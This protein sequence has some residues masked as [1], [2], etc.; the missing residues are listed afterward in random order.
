MKLNIDIYFRRKL[1]EKISTLYKNISNEEIHSIFPKKEPI[2]VT[3]IITFNGYTV[4]LY[5]MVK[6]PMFFDL[7]L[8]FEVILLPTIYT[9][10]QYPQ[11][12]KTFTTYASIIPKLSCG[13]YLMLPG[14][15]LEEPV[16]PDSF[17]DLPKNA[18]VSINVKYDKVL[19]FRIL[20]FNYANYEM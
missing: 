5:C 20:L 15:V 14:L 16:T 3:K 11:L 7:H 19:I 9:L 1:C 12:L 17:G 10:C 2:N 18:P 6:T 13:A 4:M 8:D